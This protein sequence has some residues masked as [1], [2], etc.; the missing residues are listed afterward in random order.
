MNQEISDSGAGQSVPPPAQTDL[1]P[2][3]PIA[4]AE[5]YRSI[6]ILRG[7]AVLGILVIN[8]LIFGL[9][10][11]AMTDP[12]SL[13]EPNTIGWIAW[14]ISE[15]FFFQKFMTIFSLLFGAGVILMYQ[16]AESRGIEFGR[17]YYRRIL[18]LLL[19]GFLHGCFWWGDILFSYA[20]CGL[21]IWL[22][23][24]LS[25]TKLVVIGSLVMFVAM[26]VFYG[27]GTGFNYVEQVHLEAQAALEAGEELT[28]SQQ[29]MTD[30]WRGIEE[31]M[32]GSEAAMKE[33]I[34]TFRSRPLST[35]LSNAVQA[36]VNQTFV[37]FGFVIWRAGGL[38]LI[39]MGLMKTGVFTGQ[40]SNRYYA[41]MMSLGYAAGFPL[42]LVG[43]AKLLESDFSLGTGLQVMGGVGYISSVLVGFGH[44]GL[45][46][47]LYKSGK[48]EKLMRR[49]AAV[50]RMALT[51]YVFHSVAF[52]FVFWSY[53]FGLYAYFD[54]ATLLLFVLGMWTLQLW[55]SPIWLQHFKFGPVEWLWRS[56]TYKNKQ[57]MRLA[58][59]A[60]SAAVE[61]SV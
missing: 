32:L 42:T 56:W 12:T 23:R 13:G 22:F 7:I 58:P 5:R 57:P 25:P 49:F 39:G 47:L 18:I 1:Q 43:M 33:H 28:K 61:A 29:T 6:D 53:G 10:Q 37:L 34:E 38:M 19:I 31:G 30:I 14:G 8:I 2:L 48:L 50:G 11:Q 21:L 17:T 26:S 44:V 60:E 3:G 41:W 20:V 46:M 51:N 52:V 16:R 24:R 45:I 27:L 54:R 36:V 4:A 9:P 55:L 35:F 59:A 15:L 40:R